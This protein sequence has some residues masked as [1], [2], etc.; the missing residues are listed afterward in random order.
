M[1]SN[2]HSSFKVTATP[3][4]NNEKTAISSRLGDKIP[5]GIAMNLGMCYDLIG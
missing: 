2:Y 3:K 5:E 4:N 1:R